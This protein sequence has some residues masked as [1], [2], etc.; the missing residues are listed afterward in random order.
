MQVKGRMGLVERK[1]TNAK[2]IKKE[3]SLQKFSPSKWGK[4]VLC[5]LNHD[6]KL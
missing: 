2:I 3:I 5:F 1:G 4:N 6:G